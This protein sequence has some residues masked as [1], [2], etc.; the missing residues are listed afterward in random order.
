MSNR[1]LEEDL[2]VVPRK[3][4]SRLS[5]KLGPELY[6]MLDMLDQAQQVAGDAATALRIVDQSSM[7]RDCA[8]PDEDTPLSAYGEGA[9]R[10]LAMNAL[11]LTEGRISEWL[12]SYVARHLNEAED[13]RHGVKGGD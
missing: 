12:S 2:G 7:A 4:K 8:D 13:Q 5:R 3:M 1:Y 6:V 10:R 11:S 9:L